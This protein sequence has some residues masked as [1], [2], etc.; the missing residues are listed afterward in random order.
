MAEFA[1]QT[2]DPTE[3]EYSAAVATLTRYVSDP[4][5]G[6]DFTRAERV[7]NQLN[8]WQLLL[9]ENQMHAAQDAEKD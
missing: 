8:A 3:A 5:T 6:W 7:L 4:R 1:A 9:F 2:R